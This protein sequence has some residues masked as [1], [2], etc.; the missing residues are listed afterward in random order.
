M[1]IPS[2]NSSLSEIFVFLNIILRVSVSGSY[3]TFILNIT[4]M[5]VHERA[6]FHGGLLDGC[7]LELTLTR[8]LFRRQKLQIQPQMPYHFRSNALPRLHRVFSSSFL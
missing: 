8:R 5:R 6:K 1:I 7:L 4:P 3:I 2:R